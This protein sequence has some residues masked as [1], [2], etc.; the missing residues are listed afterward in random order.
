MVQPGSAVPVPSSGFAT[1]ADADAFYAAAFSR[2]QA[3]RPAPAA[4]THLDGKS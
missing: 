3:A 1:P 2:W 4:K